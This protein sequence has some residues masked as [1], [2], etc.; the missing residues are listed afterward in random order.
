LKRL[1]TKGIGNCYYLG[2]SFRN[3]EPNSSLHLPEFNILEFY[4][5]GVN[6]LELAEEVLE[7]MRYINEKFKVQNSKF[8]NNNNPKARAKINRNR[9]IS[10]EKWEKITVTQAFQKFANISEN[11]LFDEQKF[12]QKAEKK[13]YKTKGF[14]YED[15]FS[16]I[17]SQ[18]IEPNLGVNGYPTLLYDY[19]ARLAAYAKLSADKT[20][21]E[22][23]EFYINGKEIGGGC[24]ELDD[25]K[26]YQRRFDFQT[27]K[28]RQSGLINHSI[29]N[30]F[31]EELQYGLLKCS[32]AGI[33]FERLVMILANIKLIDQ[34]KLINII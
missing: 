33:G 14:G 30:G 15:V 13:G 20:T 2:K 3:R 10:F 25:G 19:P 23:F 7:M 6:Y 11:Q 27:K 5:L 17:L 34:L 16:Q 22:R 24:T 9:E 4:K 28:R 26:E 32:G 21:A 29:D 31:L 1:L 18:E 8:K 12:I